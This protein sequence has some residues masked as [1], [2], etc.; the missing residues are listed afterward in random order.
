MSWAVPSWRKR[1][2]IW[3]TLSRLERSRTRLRQDSLFELV[4]RCSKDAAACEQMELAAMN[5]SG[6]GEWRKV[7]SK[8]T[9][10]LVEY[11]G[12]VGGG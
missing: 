11:H 9:E 2:T 10:R 12:R 4:R 1:C 6:A 3:A 7:L 5:F 8:L